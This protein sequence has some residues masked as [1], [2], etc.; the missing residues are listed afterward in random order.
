MNTD[1]ATLM[2]DLGG[3][4]GVRSCRIMARD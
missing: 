1:L 2:D 3:I 4:A